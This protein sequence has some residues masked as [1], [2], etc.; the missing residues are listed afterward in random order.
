METAEGDIVLP[1]VR[2]QS[3]LYNTE[4]VLVAL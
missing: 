2:F 3:W 1:A 4:T